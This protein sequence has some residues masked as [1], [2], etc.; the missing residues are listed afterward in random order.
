MLQAAQ[1]AIQLIEGET[2]ASLDHDL[3]LQ[4]A[5]TRSI[6]VIGEAASKITEETRAAYPHIPWSGII[7]MRNVLIHAYFNIDLDKL[8]D[9]TIT[10][11]VP[12]ISQL[13]AILNEPE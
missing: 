13:E 1:V 9:T 12:L 10:D 5:L 2:R 6:E 11:L 8:W 4:L 3:K 7:G